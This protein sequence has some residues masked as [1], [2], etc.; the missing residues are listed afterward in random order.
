MRGRERKTE[1][2]V[3]TGGRR[4]TMHLQMK[5]GS[6]RRERETE[7]S[8][9]RV[10]KRRTN[11]RLTLWFIVFVEYERTSLFSHFSSSLSLSK[12][13][14]VCVYVRGGGRAVVRTVHRTASREETSKVNWGHR[15]RERDGRRSSSDGNS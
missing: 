9:A 12:R 14:H 3:E 10:T 2:V 6:W 15:E 11:V 8:G 4:D 13:M 5:G 7:R 1:V